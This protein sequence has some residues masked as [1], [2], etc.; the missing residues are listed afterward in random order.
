MKQDK[1]ARTSRGAH[2]NGYVL[3]R[4][5]TPQLGAGRRLQALGPGEPQAPA[6]T[7]AQARGE[8]RPVWF[9]SADPDRPRAGGSL[10]A[11]DWCWP[12]GSWASAR[13]RRSA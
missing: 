3:S 5:L 6:A 12:P 2:G 10:L 1:Q 11:G 4:D 9:R 8:P 13:C 7:G